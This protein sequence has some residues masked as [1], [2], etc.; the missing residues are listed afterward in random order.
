MMKL[1]LFGAAAVIGIAASAS[2]A[3]AAD[4][5]LVS[6]PPA[7]QVALFADADTL[8]R[9]A[10]GSVSVRV[11]RID[12]V[13]RSADSVER[14]SCAEAPRP[15]H[16]PDPVRRFT[17]APAEERDNYGLI[18]ASMRP[19]EVARMIF[20]LGDGPSAERGDRF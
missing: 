6:R 11:L 5:W 14:F 12:R 9:N 8:E 1:L 7:G 17:C 3:S 16:D 2:A 4:W 10:D 13:G 20:G 15:D 19:D 18:L